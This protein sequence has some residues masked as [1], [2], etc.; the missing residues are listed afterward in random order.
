MTGVDIRPPAMAAFSAAPPR[1]VSVLSF[2]IAVT[3]SDFGFEEQ[4]DGVD[5]KWGVLEMEE[6]RGES[7]NIL[8]ACMFGS[9]SLKIIDELTNMILRF[10]ETKT[11]L[12]IFKTFEFLAHCLLLGVF[13]TYSLFKIIEKL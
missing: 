1:S 12:Y 10:D 8:E 7:S 5:L 6:G 9:F 4:S 2:A 13:Y 3:L 11:K